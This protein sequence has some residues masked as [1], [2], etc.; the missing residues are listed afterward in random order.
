MGSLI[1]YSA[2][3]RFDTLDAEHLKHTS[4]T[5]SSEQGTQVIHVR[6]RQG[7]FEGDPQAVSL[8]PGRYWIEARATNVGPLKLLVV[9]RQGETTVVYLDGT[10][11][12]T[13]AAAPGTNWVRQPSG[14]IVGWSDQGNEPTKERASVSQ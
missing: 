3:D 11:G 6:N 9:I 7:S 4:Y 2:W 14:L 13:A 12:P 8:A 1:V 10:T 5:V